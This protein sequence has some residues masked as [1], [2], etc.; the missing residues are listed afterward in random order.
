MRHFAPSEFKHFDRCDPAALA[1]L[2]DVRERCGFPLVVTDDARLP[3]DAPSGSSPTSLHYLGRA[4]DLRWPPSREAVWTFVAAVI[5]QQEVSGLGVELELVNGP[6]D[7]HLHL[8]VFPDAR[9]SR[10]LVAAD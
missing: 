6:S 10:C 5:K 2:D 8:G 9:P 1:F 4:F 3:E 7:R